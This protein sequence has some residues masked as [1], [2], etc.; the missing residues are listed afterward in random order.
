V[1][2]REVPTQIWVWAVSLPLLRIY[3]SHEGRGCPRAEGIWESPP[4]LKLAEEA[5]PKLHDRYLQI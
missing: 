1:D 5:V 2:G 4:M 3:E